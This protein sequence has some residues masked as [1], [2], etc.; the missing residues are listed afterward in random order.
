MP[1]ETRLPRDS[2][3]ELK[4][5]DLTSLLIN[6]MVPSSTMVDYLASHERTISLVSA[7]HIEF[8]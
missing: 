3:Q 7:L 5:F 8:L 6:K 2:C 1:E 4:H